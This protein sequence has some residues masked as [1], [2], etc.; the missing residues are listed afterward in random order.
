MAWMRFEPEQEAWDVIL[1]DMCFDRS[2][3]LLGE[4]PA[5]LTRMAGD[6]DRVRSHLETHQGT[7]ILAAIR[8]AGHIQPVVFSYDFDAEPRR[9]GN[10]QN[11]YAPVSYVNDVAGPREHIE[12]R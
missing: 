7:Y 8:H 6:R 9:F 11:R 2:E 5:L 3:R 4:T 12:R 10:L 1:L